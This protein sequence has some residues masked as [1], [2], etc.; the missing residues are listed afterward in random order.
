MTV[1]ERLYNLLEVRDFAWTIF[2]RDLR[3]FAIYRIDL[4]KDPSEVCIG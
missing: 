1:R 3:N 2:S 4:H